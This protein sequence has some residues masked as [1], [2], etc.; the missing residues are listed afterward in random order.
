VR[1]CGW[2][3][4]TCPCTGGRGGREVAGSARV[5]CG[6]QWAG[7]ETFSKT[8]NKALECA[9]SGTRRGSGM[10]QPLAGARDGP[11]PFRFSEVRRS[12]LGST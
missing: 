4:A 10:T 2:R 6:S 11:F 1:A 7:V 5:A 9:A 3:S 8:L 12:C